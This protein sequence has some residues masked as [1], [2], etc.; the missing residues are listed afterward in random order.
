MTAPY[1]FGYGSL[2]NTRTHDYPQPFK[3]QL[4]GWRRIWRH[5]TLRDLAILTVVPDTNCQ[6]DGLIAQVPG[7]DWSALDKR[8][9][10]Y[11]RSTVPPEVLSH[12]HSGPIE[13]QV[14]QTRTDRDAPAEARHPI[15]MSYLDIVVQGYFQQFGEQ[16]VADFFATTSGWETPVRDDRAAPQYPRFRTQTRQEL[17]LT[18]NHL[19]ALCVRIVPA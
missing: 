3:A 19:A 16:G 8:E 5:T 10:N 9:V 12:S 11:T 4:K 15:L 2:V 17:A 18:D 7:N 13:V 1:F 6:I 14:Y